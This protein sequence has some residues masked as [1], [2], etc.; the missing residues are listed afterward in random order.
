ME[1]EAQSGDL[2]RQIKAGIVLLLLCLVLVFGMQNT[3]TVNVAFLGWTLSLP[4]ALLFFFFFVVGFL[5]GLAVS[6][7]KKMTRRPAR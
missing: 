4:R 3:E 2:A 6:N 1:N 7:W 5:A